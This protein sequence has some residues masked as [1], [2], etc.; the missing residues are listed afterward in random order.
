MW[1]AITGAVANV[2]LDLYKGHQAYSHADF[3]NR[4]NVALQK[5]FAQNS[6]KWRVEDAKRAGV[7]PMAALGISGS[8][9]SPVSTS[10]PGISDSSYLSDMGQNIDRAI[11]VG[12]DQDAQ[13]EAKGFTD[14]MNQLTLE[15]MGLENDVLRA[16]IASKQAMLKQAQTPPAPKVNVSAPFGDQL[17]APPPVGSSP[18][19]GGVDSFDYSPAS[20][21]KGTV[22]GDSIVPVFHP[23][24]ADPLSESVHSSTAAKL[25]YIRSVQDKSILE[26]PRSLWSA[27][28]ARRIDSGKYHWVFNISTWKWTVEKIRPHRWESGNRHEAGGQLSN[29]HRSAYQN[30]A[31]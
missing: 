28:Q 9:F 23:D 25:A 8:S 5:E 7:H 26:P 20:M 17:D 21:F 12:K 31:F 18:P 24:I 1:G 6:I 10:I 15:K 4:Q 29:Q 16:E 14:T 13:K 3:W 19:V 22:V 30:W 27:S 11:Q 2:G